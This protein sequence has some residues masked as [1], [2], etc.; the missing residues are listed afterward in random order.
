MEIVT[1]HKGT[2][3]DA[4]ASVVAAQ[5]LFPESVG[6]LPQS[7]NPNV[8]SFI[9]LHRDLFAFSRSSEID[10][11]RVTRLIVVD[12]HQW[13]R[14]DGLQQLKKKKGSSLFRMGSQL[15]DLPHK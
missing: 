1:I 11:R 9:S 10:A 3:L 4:L 14:L 8:R 6:V 12:T 2:D 7:L 15:N 5:L 13:A